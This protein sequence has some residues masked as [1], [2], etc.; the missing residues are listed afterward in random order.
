MLLV[1]RPGRPLA[2]CPHLRGKTCS[3]CHRG[4]FSI[5]I[6]KG[7]TWDESH[8][9]APVSSQPVGFDINNLMIKNPSVLGTKWEGRRD[10]VFISPEALKNGREEPQSQNLYNS[11]PMRRERKQGIRRQAATGPASMD[12]QTQIHPATYNGTPGGLLAGPMPYCPP[13]HAPPCYGSGQFD[14][15]MTALESL[16]GLQPAPEQAPHSSIESPSTPISW[17]PM[18]LA[19]REPSYNST[20][21]M[22]QQFHMPGMERGPVPKTEPGMVHS[23][24]AQVP[25]FN[26]AEMQPGPY[27]MLNF[28]PNY[29]N[30]GFQD[31]ASTLAG[32]LD[33]NISL[34]DWHTDFRSHPTMQDAVTS[35]ALDNPPHTSMMDVPGLDP[36]TTAAGSQAA[37]VNAPMAMANAPIFPVTPSDLDFSQTA[38]VTAPGPDSATPAEFDVSSMSFIN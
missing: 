1:N 12:L 37:M 15:G 26:N 20:S 13:Y 27:N 22:D 17:N 30:Y 16:V 8:T 2:N 3:S 24:L 36:A 14:P 18:N 10:V 31:T 28:A 33:S 29:M 5:V 6:P 4:P 34:D 23:N 32:A 19:S 38:M 21:S 35:V 11:R 25:Q 7:G 9:L